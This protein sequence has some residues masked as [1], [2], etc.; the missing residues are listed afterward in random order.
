MSKALKEMVTE[1][2]R[3]RYD[4]VEEACVVDITALT[5][6]ETQA[7]RGKLR[8]KSIT[9]QVI[10]NSLARRAFADGPL[11]TLGQSLEGPCALLT[12]GDSIV[13]VAKTVAGMLKE[14][15]KI[16]LKNGLLLGDSETTPVADMA[17]MKSRLE[18]LGDLAGLVSSPGRA[19]AGA[20]SSPQGKIAGCLKAIAEKE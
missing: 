2:L 20:L 3:S 1:T 10:K 14:Y 17:K 19:L 4:G 6:E 7:V 16:V 15:P 8:E 18:I 13:E 9:C 5:V 12:G 11:D